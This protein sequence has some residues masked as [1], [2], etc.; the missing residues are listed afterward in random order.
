M[1][2]HQVSSPGPRVAHSDGEGEPRQRAQVPPGH[3]DDR[4]V[5]GLP[6]ASGAGGG[7][8][9]L[10]SC[11]PL[12]CMFPYVLDSLCTVQLRARRVPL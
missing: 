9:R 5:T 11:L 6:C 2:T 1:P 10:G 8:R 12:F 4:G 7:G 3:R